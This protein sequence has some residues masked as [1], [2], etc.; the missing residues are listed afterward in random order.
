MITARPSLHESCPSG[1][2]A[3]LRQSLSSPIPSM[4]L[5]ALLL[6]AR[7]TPAVAQIGTPAD[8]GSNQTSTVGSPAPRSV[9]TTQAALAGGSIIAIAVSNT[10]FNPPTNA[11][12]SDGAGNAYTTDVSNTDHN[13]LTTICS[14]HAL[15]GPLAAKYLAQVPSP[16]TQPNDRSWGVQKA[17]LGLFC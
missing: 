12:C 5:L 14:T 9:A 17:A 1:A 8:L 6:L 16:S 10:A 15:A 2:V 11:T 3:A 7:A 4:L 13:A